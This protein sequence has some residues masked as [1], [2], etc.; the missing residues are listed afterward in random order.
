MRQENAM[1]EF[2]IHTQSLYSHYLHNSATH[3]YVDGLSGW[4]GKVAAS[5]EIPEMERNDWIMTEHLPDTRVYNVIYSHTVLSRSR[6]KRKKHFLYNVGKTLKF[7]TKNYAF[8]RRQNR[9][10]NLIYLRFKFFSVFHCFLSVRVYV[11]CLS[12]HYRV[13]ALHR[14]CRVNMERSYWEKFLFLER[15]KRFVWSFLSKV[16]RNGF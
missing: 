8:F 13:K 12:F 4:R 14:H 9:H 10:I 15:V 6:Q 16:R 3:L 11:E 5:A 1:L 7:V 2:Q